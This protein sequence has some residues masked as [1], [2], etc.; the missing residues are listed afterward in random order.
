MNKT[1]ASEE[2]NLVL[3][4]IIIFSNSALV[5]ELVD[6]GMTEAKLLKTIHNGQ[7]T[8][9]NY[10]LFYNFFLEVMSKTNEQEIKDNINRFGSNYLKRWDL[11]SLGCNFAIGFALNPFDE[12]KVSFEFHKYIPKGQTENYYIMSKGNNEIRVPSIFVTLPKYQYKSIQSLA[13]LSRIADN[14]KRSTVKKYLTH[15]NKTKK[16]TK[17]DVLLPKSVDRDT[18]NIKILK[19]FKNVNL[20]YGNE[21]QLTLEFDS[22]SMQKE[23]RF[24]SSPGLIIRY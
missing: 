11:N 3:D 2:S 20:E 18:Q 13:D 16:L 23:I 4:H 9:G 8:V 7:G 24:Q 12:K 14:E 17:M 22:F 10:F 6:N 19:N 21:C 1:F 5:T 15:K